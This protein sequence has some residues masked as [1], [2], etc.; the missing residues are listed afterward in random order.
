MGDAHVCVCV[1]W[2]HII[3]CDPKMPELKMFNGNFKISGQY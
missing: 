2:C 1:W 3:C